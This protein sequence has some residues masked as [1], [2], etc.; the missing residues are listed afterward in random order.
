MIIERRFAWV[1]FV[2]IDSASD[3]TDGSERDDVKASA[4]KPKGL[5]LGVRVG[6]GRFPG[7]V[8]TTLPD[9]RESGRKFKLAGRG[10]AI[11]LAEV[12]VVR[13]AGAT[14]ESNFNLASLSSSSSSS[15]MRVCSWSLEDEEEDI[16]LPK[17]S[18][19]PI[20]PLPK[21]AE[22][23][24]GGN[25]GLLALEPTSDVYRTA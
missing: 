17:E 8:P 18:R 14:G 25:D 4:F 11:G 7:A 1:V 12:G 6:V 15:S 3:G 2:F 22:L 21:A 23:R 20:N 10:R 16:S 24:P 19:F 9:T 13:S 5:G